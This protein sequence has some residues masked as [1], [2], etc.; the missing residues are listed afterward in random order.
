MKKYWYLGL[1]IKYKTLISTLK[2]CIFYKKSL[3][4]NTFQEMWNLHFEGMN[5]L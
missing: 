1:I 5:K 3:T 4:L 2:L